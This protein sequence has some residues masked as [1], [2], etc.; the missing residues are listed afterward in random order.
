MVTGMS[1][2]TQSAKER[3]RLSRSTPA[4]TGTGLS[5]CGLFAGIGG[6]ELGLEATGHATVALCEIEAPA[7]SV[8]EHGFPGVTVHSD[9]RELESLPAADLVTA[10]F[11]CQDL[12]QAGTK[13]G[14]TGASSGLVAEV[15]RLIA[16]KNRPK[17]LLF[18][19]VSYMLRLDQGKAMAYLT[20][21]LESVGYRWAYR[22]V[23][24]RSFGVPQRRQRVFVLASRSEDPREVLFADDAAVDSFPDKVGDVD[25]GSL[26]GFY[27]TEGLR[28]LGWTRDAVPTIKGGSSLGIPSPP[29]IW[30]P[31]TG[32]VGTPE[33]RDAERLQGFPGGYTEPAIGAT[34]RDG[35][36]WN[37]VGNAVCVPMS[38]W[39]G[40]RLMDPSSV[41]GEERRLPDGTRWPKAAWG[42]LGGRWEVGVSLCPYSPK[43]DLSKFLEYPLRPLSPR[44]TAGFLSRAFRS[45]LNFP[46]GLID[47]LE[48]HL[49]MMQSKAV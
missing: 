12:S 21:E 19:N 48:N 47:A 44:A 8:L 49:C 24:A 13:K 32:R 7:Q 35:P 34:R 45:K 20:S 46:D 42:E 26:Y 11:P 6:I 28:G 37:L 22:T 29:A 38:K 16:D 10:G 25:A 33:I 27:W 5:T 41:A 40:N 17:W 36:R 18:E 39:I 1:F 9:I 23:D 3:E 15:F 30:D 2:D 31:S 14:I 43:Y 4:S